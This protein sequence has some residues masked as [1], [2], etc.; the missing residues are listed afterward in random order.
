MRRRHRTS[1][2]NSKK[3]PIA[4]RQR[5][6]EKEAYTLCTYLLLLGSFKGVDEV[7]NTLYFFFAGLGNAVGVLL[8]TH[9]VVEGEAAGLRDGLL[10]LGNTQAAKTT[11]EV[12]V[13]VICTIVLHLRQFIGVEQGGR[14]RRKE[15]GAAHCFGNTGAQA[16]SNKQYGNQFF[17]TRRIIRI[18]LEKP[19]VDLCMQ[20]VNK[21]ERAAVSVLFC[22]N[23]ANIVAKNLRK[24][25][26]LITHG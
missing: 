11:G 19:T 14:G 5:G 12:V 13:L 8:A 10:A 17:H 23:Q 9:P 25:I 24:Q 2:K 4:P 3:I 18:F 7:I 6:L 16:Q 21:D 22:R 20:Q 15:L 26:C 1:K